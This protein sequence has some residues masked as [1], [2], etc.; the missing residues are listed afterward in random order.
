MEYVLPMIDLSSQSAK[1]SQIV[2]RTCYSQNKRELN[3]AIINLIICHISE[4]SKCKRISI[5]LK[6]RT[7]GKCDFFP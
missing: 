2:K 6:Y 4:I 7:K 3:V 1:F 5:N